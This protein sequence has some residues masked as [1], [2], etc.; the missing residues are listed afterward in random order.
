MI[1]NNQT[2][3]KASTLTY[4]TRELLLVVDVVLTPCHKVLDV[5]WRRHLGGPLEVLRVLPQVLESVD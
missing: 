2:Q 1:S 3:V 4:P 5:F